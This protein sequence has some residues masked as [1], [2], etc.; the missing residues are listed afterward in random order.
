MN[1]VFVIYLVE[2]G[3]TVQFN[4]SISIKS[5]NTF[6]CS[7]ILMNGLYFLTPLSY[8]INVIEHIDDEQLP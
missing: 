4:S 8:N 1:L 2:H 7:E 6:I 5:N 3:L